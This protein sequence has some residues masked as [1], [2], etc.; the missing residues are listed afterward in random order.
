MG[1]CFADVLFFI[2]FPHIHSDDYVVQARL[3]LD[4]KPSI[5]YGNTQY[6]SQENTRNTNIKN[7]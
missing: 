3:F 7:H 5:N 4:S 1:G 2:L 6:Q